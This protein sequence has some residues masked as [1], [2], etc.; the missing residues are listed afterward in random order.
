MATDNSDLDDFVFGSRQLIATLPDQVDQAKIK[1]T[2]R[3][4]LL[5]VGTSPEKLVILVNVIHEAA[6]H[7]TQ[8]AHLYLELFLQAGDHITVTLPTS[9]GNVPMKRSRLARGVIVKKCQEEHSTLLRSPRWD[10]RSSDI[11]ETIAL[12][13][14]RQ[15]LDAILTD[16]V[17][18]DILCR[19]AQAEHLFEPHNFETFARLLITCEPALRNNAVTEKIAPMLE[20]VAVRAAGGTLVQ[21]F[22]VAGL[23]DV[24]D[25]G[26]NIKTRVKRILAGVVD[27]GAIMEVGQH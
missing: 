16:T 26:Y 19:A 25:N 6:H 3:F 18:Y 7:G 12:H 20:K 4:L 10:R 24:D 17:L 1:S 23:L 22:M 2:M 5:T 14:S 15:V 11:L 27:A 13:Q 8:A 9:K 21:Q